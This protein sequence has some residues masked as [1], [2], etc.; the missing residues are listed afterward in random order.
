MRTFFA[1]V[2]SICAASVTHP[3]D[4]IKIRL[5]VQGAGGAAGGKQYN[6]IFRGA[7]MVVEHEGVR[8]LYKGITASW[9]RESIYSSLRLGMYE[10]FKRLLG[11]T[12]NKN[13]PF[14]LKFMAGGMSGFIGSALANPTDLLKVRMQ[15]CEGDPKSLTWHVKDVYSQWGIAGFY[16]GIG[17]TIIRAILLN[18]TKLATYDHIKHFLINSGILADGYGCHFVSSIVAGVCIAIVTSPVDVVKTRIMN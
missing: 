11:A 2:A 4:T 5:Q 1:G 12:D 17:P 3:I 15:A 7:M 13:T 9:M 14:Y 6:N 8:G 10:P 18:A 16:R